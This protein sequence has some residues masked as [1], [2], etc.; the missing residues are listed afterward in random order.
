VRK[1]AA[2][3]QGFVTVFDGDFA[4]SAELKP[5]AVPRDRTRM[6][7]TR[8]HEQDIAEIKALHQELGQDV[9]AALDQT[10]RIQKAQG[11][12]VKEPLPRPGEPLLA[13]VHVP[14]TAGSTVKSMLAAA[15]S[16]AAIRDTGN[17]LGA[18]DATVAKVAHGG[19]GWEQWRQRGGRVTI[20]H[21][22]FGLFREHLPGDTRYMTFLRE[23]VD[24]VVSHYYRHR[25]K[26][27][28]RRAQPGRLSPRGKITTVSVGEALAEP[29]LPQL[30]NLATRFL[31]G[32]PSPTGPLSRSALEEAKANLRDFAFVGIQERFEESVV[33]LQR[34]LGLGAVP[35]EDRHVSSDRPDV[36]EIS[37][38]DRALIEEQNQL[39]AELYGF[40]LGLFEEAI[41]AADHGF[42]DEVE[43]LRGLRPEPIPGP[44]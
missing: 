11:V 37:D 3:S 18:P 23:P 42:A 38:Q 32:D 36:E 7:F 21:V 31:C 24:R 27:E 10:K 35:Y 4:A 28:P 30:N 34:M 44:G 16:S 12:K 15:Y 39:D 26:K 5:S 8:R 9:A 20:G 17:F 29:P 1:P 19:R 14:K 41:A 6:I 25:A 43:R 33:L 13:F 40:A 2:R 22:P